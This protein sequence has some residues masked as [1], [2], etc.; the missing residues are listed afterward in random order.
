MRDMTHKT[1]ENRVRRMAERQGYRLEKSRRRDPLARG[2]GLYVIIEAERR[3]PVTHEDGPGD[4]IHTLTLE[5]A[6]KWL[7]DSNRKGA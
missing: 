2:Y 4:T 5:E 1:Y 3:L 6:E 7:L